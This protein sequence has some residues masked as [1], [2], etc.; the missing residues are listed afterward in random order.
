MHLLGV[1]GPR[2]G[3]TEIVSELE[4]EKDVVEQLI[5]YPRN[6]CIEG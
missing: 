2:L 3:A 1:S 6:S 5:C 4:D